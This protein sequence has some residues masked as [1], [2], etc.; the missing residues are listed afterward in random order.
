MAR[1][2]LIQRQR[3]R[4]VLCD[5]FISKR[6]EFKKQIQ[7]CSSIEEKLDWHFKLQKLPNNSRPIRLVNRC[8]ISG[9]SKGVFQFFGLSRH[10][11]REYAHQ[12]FLPGVIKASW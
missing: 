8:L 11:I 2:S 5:K 10:F 6:L 4:Q 3:N 1:K 12:G 7:K 9:R